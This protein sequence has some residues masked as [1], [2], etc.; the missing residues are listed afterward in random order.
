MRAQMSN[1]EDYKLLL[2]Q[3]GFANASLR[4]TKS[5]SLSSETSQVKL[6]KTPNIKL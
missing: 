2:S 3:I 1:K 4:N 6:K 5:G